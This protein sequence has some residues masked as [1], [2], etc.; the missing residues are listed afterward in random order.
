[1]RWQV[2]QSSPRRIV[3]ETISSVVMDA[4]C[5]SKNIGGVSVEYLSLYAGL[6]CAVHVQTDPSTGA[7]FLEELAMA[8]VAAHQKGEAGARP[9]TIESTNQK[10][11]AN[12]VQARHTATPPPPPPPWHSRRSPHGA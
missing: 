8:F 12:L 2:F 10:A 11:A 9:G 4:V 7:H 1:M 5:G 3:M 6:M